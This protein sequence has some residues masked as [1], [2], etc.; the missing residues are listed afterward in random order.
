MT[1]S[2]NEVLEIKDFYKSILDNIISG[3]W[4][5]NADDMIY[6]TNKG[7]ENIAGIPAKQ[8]VGSYVLKDFPESTLKYFRPHYLKVKDTLKSVFYNAIPVTTPSG[9]DSYQSGWLIPKIKEDK[10]DGIICTVDDVTERKKAEEKLME[11]EAQLREINMELDQRVEERTRELKESEIEIRKIKESYERLTDNAD[12]AIFRVKIK[13]R[14]IIYSIPGNP[15]T[16]RLFG[17]SKAEWLSDST[18]GFKIIHPDFV[19]KQKQIMDDI[20]KNKKPI[21]NAVLGWIAKDGHEVIM[22]YTII[23]ILDDNGDIVYF[24]SIGVDITERKKAEL[25]LK[26]SEENYRT[27]VQNIQGIA[28]Q[29]YQDFSAALFDG[30]VSDITGYTPEDFLTGK[31]KWDNI[32]HPEDAPR[33]KLKHFIQVLLK[34]IVENIEL[35]GKMGKSGG[36]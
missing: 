9:K 29:G 23:P 11:S 18:L 10:Y 27:F 13:G 1:S 24:E 12:V 31:I 32:I 30:A 5:T 4:V 22:E 17:Y 19:E 21:K 35:L 26:Q 25:K 2:E 28:Y 36:F 15:A 34:L 16:E 14:D 20:N 6:Y 3:V 7:M 33:K 8:I